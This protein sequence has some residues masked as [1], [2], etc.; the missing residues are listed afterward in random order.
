M[1]EIGIAIFKPEMNCEWNLPNNIIRLMH[2]EEDGTIW[3]LTSCKHPAPERNISIYAYLD[4]YR[5]GYEGARLR[6]S[7]KAE[8]ADE[9]EDTGSVNQVLIKMKILQAEYTAPHVEQNAHSSF[10]EKLK[11]TLTHFLHLPHRAYDFS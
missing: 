6:V 8:I 4:F 1:E 7:G 2:T 11:H 5:K 3:F 9:T 10:L